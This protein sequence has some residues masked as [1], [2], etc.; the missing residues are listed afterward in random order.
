MIVIN[1]VKRRCAKCI[2]GEP[3]FCRIAATI[4]RTTER[5]VLVSIDYCVLIRLV[6]VRGDREHFGA[7]N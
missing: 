7:V 2:K 6:I 1:Y 3:E 5:E 4:S